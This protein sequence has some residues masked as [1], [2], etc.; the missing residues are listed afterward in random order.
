VDALRVGR[1]I[2]A[3][4]LRRRLRQADVAAR[5]HVSRSQVARIERGALDRVPLAHVVAVCAVL[6]ADLD[7][8]VRWRGD[9]LDRLLDSGH[10]A[11][12]AQ[13][14]RLLGS[15]GWDAAVEASFSVFGERGSIDVLG[16]H[17]RT[18]SLVVVEVKTAIADAQG[19]LAIH[20]RKVRLAGVVARDRGWEARSTARLLVVADR[21]TSRRRVRAL[22]ELFSTTYPDRSARV[23]QWLRTPSGRLSG[24]LFLA[25]DPGDGTVAAVA[26][27]QRVSRPRRPR[28]HAG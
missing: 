20:D 9:A 10:A 11:L 19:T 7:I 3:L 16:W 27:R 8:R 23:R 2:R 15:E 5:I 25:Y 12:V 26:G 1:S 6:G 4:R 18:A 13:V 28:M 24:L 17:P 21:S 22:N 14:V